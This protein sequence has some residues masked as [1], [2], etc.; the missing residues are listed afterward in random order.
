MPHTQS[1]NKEPSQ[2]KGKHTKLSLVS[3]G[4]ESKYAHLPACA[5]WAYQFLTRPNPRFHRHHTQESW[6]CQTSEITANCRENAE[7]VTSI[8]KRAVIFISNCYKKIHSTAFLRS[9]YCSGVWAYHHI[10]LIN[11]SAAHLSLYIPLILT[12]LINNMPSYY[13]KKIPWYCFQDFISQ[14]L[15]ILLI[16]WTKQNKKVIKLQLLHASHFSQKHNAPLGIFHKKRLRKYDRTCST[17]WVGFSRCR[18]N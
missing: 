11:L 14:I 4:Q 16:Y 6:S 9:F 15:L 8:S 2:G 12:F 13:F 7:L 5:S 17:T 1:Y 10:Y 3:L 18:A